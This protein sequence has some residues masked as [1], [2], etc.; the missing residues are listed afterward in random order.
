MSSCKVKGCRFSNHHITMRHECGTCGSLGHGRIECKSNGGTGSTCV[1]GGG[2]GDGGVGEPL[3]ETCKVDY[4]FDSE[5]HTTEGHSC[6]FC[7]KRIG[8]LKYCPILIGFKSPETIIESDISLPVGKYVVNEAGMGCHNFYRRNKTT[9]S[10][11]MFFMH[12]DSWGQYGEDTSDGPQLNAFLHG[13]SV[14]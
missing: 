1:G 7:R 11:E 3:S 9:L 13:Y 12:S 4:C 2:D 10:L 5:T 14:I 8:H 6:L